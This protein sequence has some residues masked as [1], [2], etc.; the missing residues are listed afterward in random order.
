MAKA[1]TLYTTPGCPDCAA[2][3]AWLASHG[4]AYREHD[5]SAP[6]AAD[7]ARAEF[8]VRVAPITV[9]DGQVLYGKAEEQ[10]PRL[11]VLLGVD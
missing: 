3:K 5:L 9:C 11:R 6:G 7:R 4:I 1:V 2:M 10:L 8:G